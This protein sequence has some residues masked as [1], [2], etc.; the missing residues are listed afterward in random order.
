MEVMKGNAPT[1]V[2]TDGDMVRRNAM[3]RVFPKAHHKLW[4]YLLQ[5]AKRNIGS[6]VFFSEFGK[7][8]LG[9]YDIGQFKRKWTC[10]VPKLGLE[11]NNWVNQMYDRRDMWATLYIRGSFFV[12]FRTTSRSSGL[13]SLL[14]KFVGSHYNLIEF[15]QHFQWC[16]CYMCYKQL[17]VDF[18]CK[19]GN[20]VAQ[21]N[22]PEL[23]R[24]SARV[25]TLTIFG[26]FHQV[27]VIASRFKVVDCRNKFGQLIYKLWN[28]KSQG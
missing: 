7:C 24:F 4:L 14:L 5:N 12:G 26:M 17:D 2:I 13:H 21:I 25:M 1:F 18:L 11:E 20:V 22:F 15:C 6:E 19:I 23:E 28:T 10:M 27:L 9:D 8:M 3:N 16:L